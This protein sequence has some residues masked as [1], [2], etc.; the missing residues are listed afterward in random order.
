MKQTVQG[1]F[2]A[3]SQNGIK[4]VEKVLPNENTHAIILK[5]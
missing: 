2:F 4:N 3:F 5:R 1:L